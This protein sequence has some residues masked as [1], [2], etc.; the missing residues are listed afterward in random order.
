MN[1]Q[2]PPLALAAV[3]T[4][5]VVHRADGSDIDLG[6]VAAHYADPERQ[7]AWECEGRS[8]AASRIESANAAVPGARE[9]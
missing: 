1:A 7:S 2:H 4:A 6:V 5:I 8:A 9:D 3:E